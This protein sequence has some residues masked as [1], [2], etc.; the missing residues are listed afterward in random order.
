MPESLPT[1]VSASIVHRI[2]ELRGQRVM[3]DADLAVLYGVE[4]RALLQAVKRNPERFPEDFMFRLSAEEWASLRSQ[5]V[6][7]SLRSQTVISSLRCQNG[8]TSRRHSRKHQGH[9]DSGRGRR[10]ARP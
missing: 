6:T 8:I 9:T 1:P 2:F 4:N 10:C 5:F 3:L 7:L